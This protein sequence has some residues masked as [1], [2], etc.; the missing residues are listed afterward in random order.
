MPKSK[1]LRGAMM[2]DTTIQLDTLNCG[3]IKVKDRDGNVR[4]VI[5]IDN[6]WTRRY[7]SVNVTEYDKDDTVAADKLQTVAVS[8]N[9]T[10]ERTAI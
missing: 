8:Y 7:L 10:S 9:E 4:F 3:S 6:N 5:T 2:S 1:T